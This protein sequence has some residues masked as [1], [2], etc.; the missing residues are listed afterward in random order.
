M[1]KFCVLLKLVILG[2]SNC[3]L[4]QHSFERIISEPEDQIINDVIE[5]NDGNYIMAGRIKDAESSFYSGYI[6]KFDS[7]GNS[8]QGNPSAK[9]ILPLQDY[10]FIPPGSNSSSLL[11]G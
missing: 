3:L 7:T 8:L 1:K 5:D 4:A 9:G 6:I 11:A 2:F 10:Y